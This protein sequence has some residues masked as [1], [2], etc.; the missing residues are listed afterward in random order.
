VVWSTAFGSALGDPLV[1]RPGSIG[2]T[3]GWSPLV[4]STAFGSTF[5]LTPDDPGPPLP[6]NDLSSPPP[7]P[8]APVPIGVVSIGGRGLGVLVG[9][10][11]LPSDV[12]WSIPEPVPGR[13]PELGVFSLVGPG[14]IGVVTGVGNVPAPGELNPVPAP[15]GRAVVESVWASS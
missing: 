7:V 5:G 15:P 6:G 10:A 8:L 1:P 14:V 13:V 4:W 9:D 2:A 11:G 12:S 3:P